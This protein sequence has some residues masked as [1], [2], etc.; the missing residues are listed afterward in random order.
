ME[1]AAPEIRLFSEEYGRIRRQTSK[2][3]ETSSGS[4]SENVVQCVWFDQ[5]FSDVDLVTDDGTT[6]SVV[7]PGWWN[8]GEGPDFKGAQLVLNGVEVTGDV[9]VHLDHSCW[10]QHGHHIDSRYNNL[11]LMVVLDSNPPS[12]PPYTADGR[13]IPCLLLPRYLDEDIAAI[14]GKLVLDDYPYET[15]S[16]GGKCSEFAYL[17]GA[18]EITKLLRIAGE[19]RMLS[20]A[21]ALRERMEKVG[22]DQALYETFLT[23]CGYAHFKH[24]FRAIARQFHYQRVRQLALQDPLLLEAAFMQLAGLLPDE[25]PEGCSGLPH[26]AR[27]RALRRDRLSGLRSL[28]LPWKRVAIRP[29][30]YPERRL[31]GAARFLTRTAREGITE[32]LEATWR[33]C[34]EGALTPIETRSVFEDLF[35]SP[36]GFWAEHCCWTGKAMRVPCS[37][38]GPGR[39]RC[40]IGN[41]FVPAALA[42]ARYD[43][44]RKRETQI[45]EFFEN[46]PKEPENSVLT[47]MSPRLYGPE[48]P[49]PGRMDFREQ[50]GM[51]Q[52]HQDWCEPNPSCV[53]CDVVRFLSPESV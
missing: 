51:M 36:M 21:R 50:Q 46:L 19:W 16:A 10:V 28:P 4:V 15:Q 42:I 2:T 53:D 35:P 34:G 26:F 3:R 30:N 48:A 39:V 49:R 47:L 5:L 32:T 52:I 11:I 38:I 18:G 23:A 9:E 44:E 33:A 14:A 12:K 41:V 25:L 45:L 17:H 29:V 24:H 40:I 7:S 13:R 27:L 1:N 31:A 8:Q 20:K 6:V 43:K 22:T 37:L